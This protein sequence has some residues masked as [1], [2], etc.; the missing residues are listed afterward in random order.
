LQVSTFL[1]GY[2]REMGDIEKL[3]RY[4]IIRVLGKGAM[5]VVYEGRDPNLDRVVAIK[6]IRVQTLT[7]EA[8]LEYEGRFRTEARS[9]ARLHH[10]N[11]VSVFD[12]GQD[13][14]IAYLVMEFIQGED[15][16]QHLECGA[17]FSV[18][19][20]IVMLHE[21]LMALDHAHRQ[22]VVHRDIKPANMMMEVTGRIK[23]TDF[24][25]ARI[26]EPDETNLTQVGGAV[27]TPKYMS[28]EQAKGLR[29][30]SRSDVFSAA[31]VLYELL[32]GTL[33]FTGENQ[34]IVIH[35]IV[36]HEPTPP[37]RLNPEVPPELDEV[38][39][40]A[41]AKNPDERFATARDFAVALRA[42]AQQM[43]ATTDTQGADVG[44]ELGQFL[45]NRPS[46]A[47]AALSDGSSTGIFGPSL[48]AALNST[49][50]HEAELG[51]WNAVRE[52]NSSQDFLDFLARFPAGIYARRAQNRVYQLGAGDALQGA[53]TEPQYRALARDSGF[54]STVG[55]NAVNG[56]MLA[57]GQGT[58]DSPAM[59]AESPVAAPAMGEATKKGRNARHLIVGG[60]VLAGLVALFLGFNPGITGRQDAIPVTASEAPV[61]PAAVV[62]SE[63]VPVLTVASAP[64]AA[65]ALKAG[66]APQPGASKPV[67]KPRLASSAPSVPAAAAAAVQPP[68]GES[69]P[70]VVTPAQVQLPR[71]S[72]GPSMPGQVCEDRV[73]IFKIT[74]IAE[75]CLTDRYRHTAECLRF[76]EMEREREEQRNSRR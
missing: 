33:P 55:C 1:R 31:V 22:N 68:P 60:S 37:S 30:D 27:G 66:S 2:G 43:N 26:Q 13:G 57:P 25:V 72:Q 20:S 63:P 15:L 64:V 19:S 67:A 29:G 32:T 46:Q 35:Q 39:A 7:P 59:V 76:K 45:A 16:K 18:R 23:L 6:T 12:S 58:P 36:S 52:S 70:A 8:A 38:I 17:R 42:V 69:A 75:Q 4:D 44:A 73:F 41:M 48:E 24:G 10:P 40:R 5:G 50:N 62:P 28:P 14:G 54:E 61:L 53:K 56:P 3:G 47:P 74:C 9:A 65:P 21:L 11:I 51:A 71:L 49:V 34:F